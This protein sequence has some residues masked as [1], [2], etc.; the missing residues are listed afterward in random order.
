VFFSLI[1]IAP[2]R[3][4]DI[5]VAHL[6]SFTMASFDSY[7]NYGSDKFHHNDVTKRTARFIERQ[8]GPYTHTMSLN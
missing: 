6:C 1:L 2:K 3:L 8:T 5:S 4:A 7:Y